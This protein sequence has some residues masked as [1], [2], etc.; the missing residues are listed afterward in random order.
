MKR[1]TFLR[2]SAQAAMAIPIL[3]SSP[4]EGPPES[5]P[6]GM[7]LYSIATLLS[8]N[9][10]E[11]MRTL[12]GI[13]YRELE[14]AGPY[15]FSSTEEKEN[16]IMLKQLGLKG[17][18]YYDL[19][20][21]EL[22]LFLDELGLEAPSAHISIQSLEYNLEEALNAAHIVGH[23]YLICPMA[24]LKSLDEY[25]A[26]AEKFNSIGEACR[27]AGIHFGFHNHSLEF[28][29]MSGEVPMKVLL[30]RTQPD[31]VSFE[32][33]VFWTEVAGV[34]PVKY[35]TDFPGRFHLMHL[36][37]MTRKMAAPNTEWQTFT[38]PAK[39]RAMFGLEANV[40]DGMINFRRIIEGTRRAGVKHYFA[41]RD[42][43]PDPVEFMN[44]SFTNL[45]T[46]LK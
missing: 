19:A 15:Y 7:Q 32:L 8:E 46:L 37:D 14:F 42:F 3:G 34:D 31:L 45:K 21:K 26:L 36:K 6:V 12:S 11:T 29:T 44:R 2:N 43:P 23:N 1:R 17:Y 20:P 35:L 25:K 13:G 28:A 41:E 10:R 38:D 33:D 40:G 22:R 4:A 9:F 27:K 16:S 30:N 24:V 5:K 39:A 18:G